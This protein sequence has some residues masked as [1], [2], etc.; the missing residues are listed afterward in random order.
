MA[1]ASQASTSDGINIKIK[2]MQPATYDVKIPAQV[3]TARHLLPLLLAFAGFG[4]KQTTS[5]QIT[6]AELKERLVDIANVP[7]E[8]QRVIYKG[9]VLE[10]DQQLSSHGK[11]TCPALSLH[12]LLPPQVTQRVVCAGVQEGHTLHLVERVPRPPQ[13]AAGQPA[14]QPGHSKPKHDV[15]AGAM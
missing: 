14:E 12:C 7:Q 4:V 2:T 9:R 5:L 8:R 15:A 3:N 11:D 6:V 10:N 1:E 13:P